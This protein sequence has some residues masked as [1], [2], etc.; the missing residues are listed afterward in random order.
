MSLPFLAPLRRFS[1]LGNSL[2]DWA[3][4]LAVTILATA[5]MALVRSMVLRRLAAR[6]AIT[7]TRLDDLVVTMLS[8]TYLLFI[9]AFGIYF[10]STFLVLGRARELFIDRVAVAALLM[11][12]AI[13]GD[14]GLRAWRDQLRRDQDIAR[15]NSS[16]VLG[17]ILRLTLWVIVFLVVLDNF[18]VN[19]TALVASL[20][21]GGIAVALAVQNILGDLFASLSITLDKP[22]E[23][24]D[25]I[26]V[27]DVLG[28]VEHIGLKTTRL[29]GLGGEQVV[30]SNGDLL[31]SRIHNHKRMETRR[32]AFVLRIAYGTTE[33][34]L[35]KVPRIIREIVTAKPNIDFERAHFF[36][37]G[38]WSLDFEVV[39]HF[40]SPDYVLHMDAQQDIFFEIYRRFE[41]EGIRFAHPLSIIRLADPPAGLFQGSAEAQ[42]RNWRH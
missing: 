20:G 4:A 14:V 27:G 36:M 7:D 15:R 6:S 29:R 28:S 42:G 11:Q 17:F 39:Y 41:K 22:F 24:G 13:W 38:E 9:V 26:I 18:G 32:V 8:K 23:I 37:W 19:I 30:F 16:S 1:F 35:C 40:R 3:V 5:A 12:V 34:L 31:K 2:E 25:F 10:G 33:E 21:V